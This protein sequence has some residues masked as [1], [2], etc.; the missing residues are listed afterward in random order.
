MLR[1]LIHLTGTSGHVSSC[2]YGVSSWIL[3]LFWIMSSD[4]TINVVLVNDFTMYVPS[5]LL[6]NQVRLKTNKLFTHNEISCLCFT[7]LTFRILR[8]FHPKFSK[9]SLG[10]QSG[11]I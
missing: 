7:G 5:Q 1:F 8:L 9:Y 10:K 4:S 2:P 6:N 11:S 3:D